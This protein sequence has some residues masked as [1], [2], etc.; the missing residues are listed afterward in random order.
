MFEGLT[1]YIPDLE[2][3]EKAARSLSKIEDAVYH[4]VHNHPECGWLGVMGLLT[5]AMAEE[6]R[7][8]GTLKGLYEDGS[9]LRWLKELKKA[10]E[11]R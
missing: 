2:Q 4:F 3:E 6:R 1:K 8:L 9:L 11:Q 5:A 10:D 7:N